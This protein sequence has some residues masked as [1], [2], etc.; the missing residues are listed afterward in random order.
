MPRRKTNEEYIEEC[1]QHGYDLP[2]EE[3]KGSSMNIKHKCNKCGNVYLQTPHEHLKGSSCPK[4]HGTHKKTTQEYIKECKQKGYDLPI[5]KYVNATTKIKHK[6]SK[7]GNSYLQTPHSHLKGRGCPKCA[8]ERT[9]S[10]IRKE[11]ATYIKDCNKLGID[12]PIEY[13]VNNRTP[14][15]HK[16]SKG[17][18]YKQTPS[19]HLQGQGCPYCA[20]RGGIKK[21]SKEYIKDCRQRGI[22]LPI[23]EYKGSRVPIKHKCSKGHIYKQIPYM[24]LHYGCGCPICNESHGEKYVRNYLDKHNI[25]YISQKKFN[26]LKD[27]QPLS[28]DFYLPKQKVLI[29]YQGIQHF[30]SVSFGSKVSSDIQ[31]QQYHDKLKHDYAINNGYTLLEP[32]YKLDT[33]E[34]INKYLDKYL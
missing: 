19:H 34:K 16:C 27:K 24:R 4:C 33:Q 18:I 9:L 5:N 3:Y 28:Y 32:T 7:C 15:K 21:T 8:R 14:I 10:S 1:K 23:E 22:D 25:P 29:E 17:H 26:E 20:T 12:L 30:E 31:T 11:H 6:C 2:I 13:Y